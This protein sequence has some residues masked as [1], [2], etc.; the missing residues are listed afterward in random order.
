MESCSVSIEK[1]PS[2]LEREV[3]FLGKMIDASLRD[4]QSSSTLKKKIFS[5]LKTLDS[6]HH[7]GVNKVWILQFLLLPQ[8]RWTL[9]NYEIPISMVEQLERKISKCIRKKK[10]YIYN[11]PP[12]QNPGYV[13]YRKPVSDYGHS[14]HISQNP[15]SPIF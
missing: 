10:I 6:S 12:K 3:R 7:L 8:V 9:M 2:I 14:V 1:T 13:E 4:T 11:Y 5:A 15:P